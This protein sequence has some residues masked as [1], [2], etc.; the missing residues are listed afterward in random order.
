MYK[1]VQEL[2]MPNNYASNMGQCVNIEQGRF[3]GIK[4]HDCHVFMEC[5]LPLASR[6]LVDHIW[7]PVTEL[8]KYFKDLCSFM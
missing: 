3:L 1:L 6:E 4:S 2:E 8:S 7:K 5:L